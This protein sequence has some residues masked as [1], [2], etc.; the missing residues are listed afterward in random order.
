MVRIPCDGTGD[1]RFRCREEGTNTGGSLS[2]ELGGDRALPALLRRPF[3][4]D[5][6]LQLFVRKVVS[7]NRVPCNGRHSKRGRKHAPKPR[8]HE[9]H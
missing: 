6:F 4:P 9:T 7:G 2:L 8:V 3:P 5:L 1:A